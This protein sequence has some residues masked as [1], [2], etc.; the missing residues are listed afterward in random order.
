MPGLWGAQLDGTSPSAFKHIFK[1]AVPAVPSWKRHSSELLQRLVVS[2]V[3]VRK[4]TLLPNV[5]CVV[6]ECWMSKAAAELVSI[7][8]IFDLT[9]KHQL[10]LTGNLENSEHTLHPASESSKQGMADSAC[11]ALHVSWNR[12]DVG[13]GKQLQHWKHISFPIAF[14]SVSSPHHRGEKWLLVIA[15]KKKEINPDKYRFGVW[16]S[17]KNYSAGLALG[18]D[19]RQFLFDYSR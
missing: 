19:K 13:L 5:S 7:L 2:V 12:D 14:L 18:Q 8:S 17:F 3:T 9:K 11:A 15:E 6:R 10:N 4:A 16:H 1:G